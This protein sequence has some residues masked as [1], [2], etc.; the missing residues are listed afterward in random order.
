MTKF[1]KNYKLH[2]Y[3]N[4]LNSQNKGTWSIKHDQ[5]S[6]DQVKVFLFLKDRGPHMNKWLFSIDQYDWKKIVIWNSR[7][8]WISCCTTAYYCILC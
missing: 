4:Y 8:L 1:K 5:Y 2:E 7:D 3:Y 6:P